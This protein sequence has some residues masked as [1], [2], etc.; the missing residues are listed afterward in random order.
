MSR[1]RTHTQ[2]TRYQ[3][4]LALIIALVFGALGP[5][6][7]FPCVAQPRQ[8]L[9]PMVEEGALPSGSAAPSPPPQTAAQTRPAAN[10][11]IYGFGM[12]D[13]GYN[14]GQIDPN[15]F[16][17]MRPSKLPAFDGEFGRNGNW[18][19]G[20]RQSRLGFKAEVPAGKHVI[21][22]VVDFDFLASA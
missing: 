11:E 16:D 20:A 21:K 14:A 4:R 17:V 2:G 15:W 18:F 13:N 8:D 9:D 12:L 5:P 22:T 10:L 1:S 6:G 19:A 7:V 3:T